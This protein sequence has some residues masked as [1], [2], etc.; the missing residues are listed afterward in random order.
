MEE[1]C[2]RKNFTTEAISKIEFL[3]LIYV[4]N[5]SLHKKFSDDIKVLFPITESRTITNNIVYIKYDR[6]KKKTE[7]ITECNIWDKQRNRRITLSKNVLMLVQNEYSAYKD[8]SN[9]FLVS[10][11]SIHSIYNNLIIKR[12]GVR[13]I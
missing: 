7:E 3:N 12:F 9:E 1:I 2:Y 6:V 13:Y 11:N 4:L 8:F 10:L 5:K